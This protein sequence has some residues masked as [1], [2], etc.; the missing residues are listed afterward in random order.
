MASG[1]LLPPG[2][3]ML[4]DPQSNRPYYVNH[5]TQQTSWNPPIPLPNGWE[6]KKDDHGR[7]FYFNLLTNQ[8]TW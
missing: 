6:E 2:W 7:T 8:T 4:I 1:T 5:E 3:E